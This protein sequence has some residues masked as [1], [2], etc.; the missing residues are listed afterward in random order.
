MRKILIIT[1]RYL[2]GWR[3]GGPVRSIVNLVDWLGDE[4]DFTIICSDRDHGDNAPYPDIKINDYNAVGKAKVW[5]TPAYSEEDIEKLASGSDVVYVCGPYNDY[6]RLTMKLK[7]A[8]KIT[9]PLY[10]ASMGSF[11]PEAF[12]IKGFK[13]R[14]FIKYMKASGMFDEV[15]WS[16]TSP[17]E[18]EELKSVIGKRSRCIIAKDLPR[19]TLTEHTRS[20]EDDFLKVCFISRISRK[21]NLIA[22]PDIFSKIDDDHRIHLDIYGACEDE[23]YF[24]ECSQ[25]FDDLCREHP[26][27]SWEY[28][29]EADGETVPSLFAGYDAFLFPTLGEN[30][31]HVIAESLAA[32]CIPVISDT[33]PWLDLL[34]E[35]CGYVC[36]LK[37]GAAF[38]RAVDELFHMTEDRMSDMRKKCTEYITAINEDSVRDSGYRHIFEK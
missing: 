28:K 1:G 24:R 2:P 17:R 19:R 33:T 8:G 31:G 18:E 29:G 6:A 22:I 10:V 20:K 34:D 32:G 35:G 12:K 27:Y 4:Y 26:H 16:V 38:A 30:Y 37:D 21:K 15:I 23:E 9:A 25:K 14:L 5:Y 3:D 11:S 13:K 36:H 7:R